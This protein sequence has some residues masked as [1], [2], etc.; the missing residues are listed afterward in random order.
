MRVELA[1]H[2]EQTL[3]I[4]R[5]ALMNDVEILGYD[6]NARQNRRRA[7][8]DDKFNVALDE[9]RQQ[10]DDRIV[11]LTRHRLPPCADLRDAASRS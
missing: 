1:E 7:T 2:R 3:D 10:T 11:R 5:R 9:H 6:R 8:H 4:F